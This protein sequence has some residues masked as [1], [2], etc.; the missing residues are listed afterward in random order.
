VPYPFF[1][2]LQATLWGTKGSKLRVEK[3]RSCSCWFGLWLLA[4]SDWGIRSKNST[5]LARVWERRKIWITSKVRSFT[6]FKSLLV[7][8]LTEYVS[9]YSNLKI[10]YS[11][12]LL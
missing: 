11:S 9:F 1:L 12:N 7:V 6:W 10:C 4:S 2:I 5:P 3:A 8:N